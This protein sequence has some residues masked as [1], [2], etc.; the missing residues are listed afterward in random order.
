MRVAVFIDG[1]NF[2]NGCRVSSWE[3]QFLASSPDARRRILDRLVTV[4]RLEVY[5]TDNG[6]KALRIT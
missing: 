6:K 4:G 5:L 3:A 1:K 2:Y